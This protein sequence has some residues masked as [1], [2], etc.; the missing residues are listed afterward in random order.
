MNTQDHCGQSKQLYILT[1][2]KDLSPK[3]AKDGSI[4]IEQAETHSQ[5]N[6]KI[7]KTEKSGKKPVTIRKNDLEKRQDFEF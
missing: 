2:L 6:I 7:E 1:R 3:L 5:E 4:D